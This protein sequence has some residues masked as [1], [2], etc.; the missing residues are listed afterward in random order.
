MLF[1]KLTSVG[2]T[3][4]GKN[5]NQIR[6]YAKIKII[7]ASNCTT[8]MF[9]KTGKEKKIKIQCILSTLNA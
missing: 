5:F 7:L 4:K 2:N 9:S 6:L 1:Q 8:T 3:T